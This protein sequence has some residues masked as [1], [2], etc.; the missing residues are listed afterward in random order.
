MVDWLRTEMLKQLDWLVTFVKQYG[1]DTPKTIIFGN[2]LYAVANVMNYLM[3]SLGA[4]AFHPNTSEKRQDCLL[5][6]FH[7]LS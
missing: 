4:N 2:T 6:I 7:C 1:K 3:I 5:G